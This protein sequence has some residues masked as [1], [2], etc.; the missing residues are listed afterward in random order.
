[1]KLSILI[2]SVL[3][4]GT[5]FLPKI[6][7][8]LQDQIAPYN[9]CV[10]LLVLID[11]CT[12][13]MLGDKRNQLVNMA[14][15]KYCVA[16]DDDDQIADDYIKTLIN[17]IDHNDVDVIN[18]ICN[19]SLND[20]PYKPCYYS[21]QFIQDHNLKDRYNR[22]PNHISCVKRDL[23]LSTP[24]NNVIYGEDADYSK[25]LLPKLKTEY[26]INQVLYYYNYN[27]ETTI[28]QKQL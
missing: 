27:S 26:N 9:N 10:E 2:C 13:F 28:K 4:R 14:K 1:M 25:R 11:N 20:G 23:M 7:K 19:V 15:G 17:A 12:S 5:T 18:F 8:Q 16:I 22:I 24:F 6:L 21:L 3:E